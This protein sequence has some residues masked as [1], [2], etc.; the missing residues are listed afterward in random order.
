[1]QPAVQ[2]GPDEPSH[3]ST[4]RQKESELRV[5]GELD[6]ELLLGYVVGHP[7]TILRQRFTRWT[8]STH[9]GLVRTFVKPSCTSCEL[10]SEETEDGRPH[11]LDA[12]RKSTRLNSSH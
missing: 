6:V 11:L 3:N 7:G 4:R 8:R 1:M 10:L 9:E 12:D 5:L 2:P